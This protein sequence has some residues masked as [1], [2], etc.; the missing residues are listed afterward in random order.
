MV[1]VLPSLL[2]LWCGDRTQ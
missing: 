1:S 2:W